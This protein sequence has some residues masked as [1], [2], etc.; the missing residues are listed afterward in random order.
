MWL[1]ILY[2]NRVH[3]VAMALIKTFH[4][5]TFHHQKLSKHPV[6]VRT[7]SSTSLKIPQGHLKD[8]HVFCSELQNEPCPL[9][10]V[11]LPVFCAPCAIAWSRLYRSSQ[12]TSHSSAFHLIIFKTA[13]ESLLSAAGPQGMMMVS[14]FP[15]HSHSLLA[16]L[17]F[18]VVFVFL[19]AVQRLN[20]I[21]S[22]GPSHSLPILFSL[23]TFLFCC[24]FF[25][26]SYSVSHF[27]FYFPPCFSFYSLLSVCFCLQRSHRYS[28]NIVCE[29][30]RESD[31]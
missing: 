2:S 8:F 10:Y 19:V 20:L 7:G 15:G 22:G 5:P 14:R 9:T 18:T 21:L 29:V 12:V 11:L 26:R 31:I 13:S 27:F 28:K 24:L 17:F 30:F 16:P 23:S 25:S 6:R 4:P 3:P 1:C